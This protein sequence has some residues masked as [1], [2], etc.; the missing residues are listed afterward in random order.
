[1]RTA[2]LLAVLAVL[3]APLAA[4][5]YH[6]VYGGGH[7]PSKLRVVLVRTL[8]PDV[9]ASDEVVSGLREEL[10]RAGA[11]E[12]GDGFPRVEVEV[13]RA[14]E[15]SEGIVAGPSGPVSRATDVGIAARA[16]IVRAEG[17]PPESD[18]GD[19]RAEETIAVDESGSGA[20]QR[21]DPRASS[22]HEADALRAAARRLGRSLGAKVTG[23]PASS[24]DGDQT[25]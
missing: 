5:G 1:M 2:S 14:D 25:R 24:D 18:T 16:W 13:L 21:P 6:A 4:C 20:N 17:A 22:F 19:L 7:V 15:A 23:Q 10:A 12:P 3:A 8:V 11:L 9:V